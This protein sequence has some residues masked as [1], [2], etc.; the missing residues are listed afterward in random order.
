MLDDKPEIAPVTAML[1]GASHVAG[2]LG[3]A[4]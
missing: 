4:E 3:A 2:V 1:S